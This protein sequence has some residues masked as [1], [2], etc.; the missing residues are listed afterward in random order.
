MDLKRKI[1][2]VTGAA[3]GIGKTIAREFAEHGSH[4]ALVDLLS[5]PLKKTA[6]EAAT[7]RPCFS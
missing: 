7:R 2:V 6:A 1:V 4:L 3:R 5:D